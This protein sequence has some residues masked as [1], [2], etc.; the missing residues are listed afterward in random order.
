MKKLLICL[1][2]P[3]IMFAFTGCGDHSETSPQIE[4]NKNY[5]ELTV[6]AAA[7]M[8]DLLHEVRDLYHQLHPEV[9]IIFNFASS[10]T[11][12]NQIERGAPVDVFISAGERE[13]QELTEAGL[14]EK[15]EIFTL[16]QNRLVMI[17][18]DTS[19][20]MRIQQL[21]DLLSAGVHKIAVGDPQTVPAGYYTKQV[22]ERERLYESLRH[23][24]VYAKDVRQVLTYVES[25]NVDAGFVYQ[26]DLIASD[27]VIDV[28]MIDE[29]GHDP[30][31]Y[32]GAVIGSSSYPEQSRVFLQFF[33]NE[34]VTEMIKQYGFSVSS[35]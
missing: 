5:V 7:S 15:N 29:S 19:S 4:G 26:S 31:L 18:P 32:P 33:E 12:K 27:R 9:R 34:Q 20:R 35:D 3:F 2:F 10:G 13:M 21:S 14:V 16:A 30:I 1:L 28:L 11:L 6:S 24:L 25:G 22:L 23:K 17:I 8:T